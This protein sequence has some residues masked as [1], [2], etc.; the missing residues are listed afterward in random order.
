MIALI[1]VLLI[2]LL[3]ALLRFGVAVEYNDEGFNATA[4]IGPLRIKV[5]PK[6]PKSEKER[7][8]AK[9]R[10]KD[11]RKRRKK[12]KQPLKSPVR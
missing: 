10:R 6:K 3:I 2:L 11:K 4:S 12:R 1:V 9:K 7:K 5:Y 8:E